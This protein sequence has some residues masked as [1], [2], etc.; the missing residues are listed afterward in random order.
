MHGPD[1]LHG[2]PLALRDL[3]V[4]A[5][6]GRRLLH[7]PRLDLAAGRS[8]AIRG[9]SGAGKSTLLHVLAGL[10]GVARG[11]VAWGNHDLA[12]MSD[13]QR[14]RFR[15]RHIGQIF[16]DYLLFDELSALQNAALPRMFA[17][18]ADRAAILERA[19]AWLERLG[20]D[21]ADGRTSS[22]YSGGERQRIA[23]ARAMA[24]DP[25]VLL[26]DEPTA[27]LD[28]AT[29]DRLVAD[30]LGAVSFGGPTLVCVTHDD[31]LC[32][33][34]DHRLSLADGL[35]ERVHAA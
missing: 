3:V 29:A 26:A 4:T 21:P 5:P 31:R 15:R 1:R 19:R 25:A 14:S 32:E 22:A 30:L 7:V 35:P 11:S 12:G 33:R 24:Q 23:V 10:L 2:L 13:M 8:L 9:P 18:A 27:S 34:L 16:Q 6:S 28:R 17:P 20:L